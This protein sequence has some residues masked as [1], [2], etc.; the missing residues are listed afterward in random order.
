MIELLNENYHRHHFDMKVAGPV[1]I[2]TI[3]VL[4]ITIIATLSI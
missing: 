4:I 3:I 2:I 1:A